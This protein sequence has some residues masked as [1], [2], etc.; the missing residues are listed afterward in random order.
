M[1]AQS[2]AA[3]P[4]AD[5][6]PTA[7]HGGPIAFAT[8]DQ[9]PKEQL[10]FTTERLVVFKDGYGLVI[11]KGTATA[12]ADGHVY[13]D[14]VP[15]N[16]IL[17]CFWATADNGNAL[18]MRAEWTQK[19]QTR[20]V[21]T[22]CLSVVDLLRA[23]MGKAV[24]LQLTDKTDRG[25]LLTEEG[26]LV[27]MLD[28]P[29]VS[30]PVGTGHSDAAALGA[31]ATGASPATFTML[32][33][34]GVVT[35]GE[36]TPASIAAEGGTLVRDLAPRGGEF[37]CLQRDADRI[38]IPV[39]HIQNVAGKDL[40]TTIAHR[41]EIYTH[42]KRLGFDL[43]KDAAAKGVALHMYYFTPG[44]RW[45]PTYRV[46]G[47]L[48]DKADVSL[49]GE[50]LN[51]VTDVEH[52]ALDLVVGVPNFKF[53]GT[54]SPLTFER[55]MRGVMAN[56]ENRLFTNANN[57]SQSQYMSNGNNEV[58]PARAAEGAVAADMS[59]APEL[60]GTSGE[61]DMFV[62]SSADFSLKKGARATLPL[63]QQSAA[64]RHLYTY[65][66]HTHRSRSSGAL[67][68]RAG[69]GEG[70]EQAGMASPNKIEMNQVW[71]QLELS[72]AGK[73]PWTTGAAL[74]IQNNL[75]LGQDLMTYTSIGGRTYLPV[76]IA[77]DL[78]GSC[79]EVEAERKNNA[80]RVEG[81][82]YAQITK[83]GTITLTSFRK[84]KSDMRIT[85]S[86][87]GKVTAASDDGKIQIN[88]YRTDDWDEPT[89]MR[90]NNHSDVSWEVSLD[91]GQTKKI[92][93][94]VT[95]YVR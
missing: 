50:I 80:L 41:Q 72:N 16:A 94:E 27:E 88:D 22:N 57:F 5:S 71:H 43:G 62:Y 55:I 77:V 86:A 46:A 13:A 61:Q 28:A 36:F 54:P 2:C 89:F 87:G 32:I 33:R 74:M 56:M 20:Q 37:V 78:R 49:Q 64:L 7:T 18:A 91:P 40:N 83:K 63:W 19:S 31:V 30:I 69:R 6:A 81:Y 82:D 15:D 84:E 38:I 24:T 58:G 11:K 53:K 95:F 52:C 45:I 35:Y 17:G 75:P 12:D 34:E 65:D 29:S 73:F 14:D 25:V 85:L 8:S 21:Q 70:P 90:V 76:T 39:S 3:E 26:H 10:Q 68:E 23:N 79:D 60:A 47:E 51:D 42:A 9:T 48:K 66:I 44:L 93:Y 4:P 59:M 1:Q 92:T 67:A